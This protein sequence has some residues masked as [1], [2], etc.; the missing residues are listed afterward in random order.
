MDDVLPPN[1][2]TYSITTPSR[3]R[4]STER[5]HLA[6][7]PGNTKQQLVQDVG[8]N[9]IQILPQLHLL[10]GL[11]DDPH[12]G[13]GR[14]DGGETS[15]MGADDG[16]EGMLRLAQVQKLLPLHAGAT[17]AQQASNLRHL[18]GVTFA[19]GGKGRQQVGSLRDAGTA[20][21][22]TL[23]QHQVT[24]MR[25]LPQ[26]QPVASV[27]IQSERLLVAKQVHQQFPL[28]RLDQLSEQQVILRR[29]VGT[30]RQQQANHCPLLVLDGGSQWHLLA[31][32][33]ITSGLGQ[34]QFNHFQVAMHARQDQGLVHLGTWVGTASQELTSQ[35]DLAFG[36][37]GPEDKVIVRVD[38]STLLQ[39]VQDDRF[40]LELAGRSK[41]MV[42]TDV[43]ISTVLDNHSDGIQVTVLRRDSKRIIAVDVNVS[44]RVRGTL[45]G[46]LLE[47]KLQ[48]VE[49]VVGSAP[50]QEELVVSLQIGAASHHDRENTGVQERMRQVVDDGEIFL[51]VGTLLAESVLKVHGA[52][53]VAS[54]DGVEGLVHEAQLRMDGQREYLLKKFHGQV[55]NGGHLCFVSW[56]V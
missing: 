13:R 50:S 9:V 35:R 30:V 24:T 4:Q 11:R 16:A 21:H 44:L 47:V 33:H 41:R 2:A 51:G 39:Q 17:L 15:L 12:I 8:S 28:I 37:R 52:G 27:H 32:M 42:L 34:Q 23:H 40:M 19:T 53:A 31:S 45:V 3:N 22:E 6:K 43:D 56:Y 26:Q 5:S 29:G 48:E 54:T 20:L 14:L 7:S 25:R 18:C 10:D 36:S 49:V 1:W 46:K 55:L 38:I